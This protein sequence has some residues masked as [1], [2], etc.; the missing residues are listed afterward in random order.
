M[1]RD[2]GLLSVDEYAFHKCYKLNNVVLPNSTQRIDKEAFRYCSSLSTITLSNSLNYINEYAFADCP[3]LNNVTL[4]QSLKSIQNAAF[5]N[6]VALSGIIFPEGLEGI[7]AAAFANCS[8][9]QEVQFN[10]KHYNMTIGV[11]A[12]NGS[13]AIKKVKVAHLDSWVSIN[14]S[15]PDANPASISHRLYDM[16]NHEIINAVVPE[17][18]IYVNNNA[19][20]GCQ[21]LKS[22]TLP[23]STQFINDNIFYGCSSLNKVISKATTPPMFLGVLDPGLMNDVFSAADLYVEEASVGAYSSDSWWKRFRSV[24]NVN[25]PD[26]PTSEMVDMTKDMFHEWDGCTATSKVTQE[27]CG[28]GLN[29]G[30]NLPSGSLVYGDA[31]VR[32]THYADLTGYNTLLITGTPGMQFRVLINRL[33]VGNGG[34][35]ANGGAYTELNP[36]IGTDGTVAVDLSG[37]EFVHLNS[38]KTGWNSPEGIIESLKVSTEK[39]E[40]PDAI[41]D[42]KADGVTSVRKVFRKGRIVII[43]NGKEYSVDGTLLK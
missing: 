7:G 5:N 1:S 24:R 34:G 6:D 28:G 41:E 9:L 42:V 25:D 31:S 3:V 17:G 29:L 14:F 15:N 23:A 20:Y 30:T 36:T 21:N 22:V 4:P 2:A 27:D 33:E 8:A 35:D 19:F 43:K 39:M 12:F 11:N 18:S 16:D 38:I 13:N 32:Y 37:Y 26:Q 40:Q 10:T